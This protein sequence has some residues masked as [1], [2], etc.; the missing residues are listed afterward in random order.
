[1]KFMRDS[2]QIVFH[3]YLFYRPSVIL[4]ESLNVGVESIVSGIFFD[5]SSR[6][7]INI[8]VNQAEIRFVICKYNFSF[9][10]QDLIFCI[11]YFRRLEDTVFLEQLNRVQAFILLEI[12]N[13]LDKCGYCLLQKAETYFK[14]ANC[15]A[16][17]HSPCTCR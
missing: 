13:W 3:A 17:V 16:H 5:F 6:R 10:I 12:A 7:L 15:Y 2:S 8:E 11:F 9:L 4:K 1:M 14:F